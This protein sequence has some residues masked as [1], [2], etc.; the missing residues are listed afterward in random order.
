MILIS[1]SIFNIYPSVVFGI[2]PSQLP[3]PTISVDIATPEPPAPSPE[4]ISPFPTFANPTQNEAA[5]ELRTTTPFTTRTQ[6]P[7]HGPDFGTPFG[8]NGIYV[9][10]EV[11]PGE[12]FPLLAD[13]YQTTPEVIRALNSR[14]GSVGLW[15]GEVLVIMPGQT[16]LYGLPKFKVIQLDQARTLNQLAEEYGVSVSE[17]QIYNSLGPDSDNIPAGRWIII[18]VG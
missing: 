4:R 13:N 5:G 15:I 9:L 17:L 12:S 2:F 10:H 3:S 16:D 18:P 6:E 14:Q 7:T 1:F 11:K 8:P